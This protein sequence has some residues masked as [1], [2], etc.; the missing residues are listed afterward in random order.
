MHRLYH[1]KQIRPGT[2]FVNET[3]WSS[4]KADELMDQA[5]VEVNSRKRA[6]LY[7]EMQKIVVEGSPL[8]WVHELQFVTVYNKQFK[9]LI[10]SPLGL[11]A[12]FDRAHSDK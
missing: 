10:V 4:P 11:Y 2:V 6:A 12:S 9:D 5:T 3:G 7:K 1:S 8:V